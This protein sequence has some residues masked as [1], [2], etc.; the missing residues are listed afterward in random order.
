MPGLPGKLNG[1]R[2]DTHEAA[3][4]CLKRLPAHLKIKTIVL[5]FLKFCLLLATKK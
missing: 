2:V 5:P 3:D 4:L 1:K